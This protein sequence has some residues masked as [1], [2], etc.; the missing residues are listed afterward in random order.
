[1]PS[2]NNRPA[3]YK[4]EAKLRARRGRLGC[5]QATEVGSLRLGRYPFAAAIKHYEERRLGLVG[6]ST[7]REE[8]KTLRHLNEVFEQLKAEEEAK[9]TED[10]NRSG[11]EM[12]KP[13]TTDPRRMG[14][15][16]IQTFMAWMRR[17]GLDPATQVTYMKRLKNFLKVFRN[18]VIDDMVAD[19]VRFPK[20]P[21]KPIRTLDMDDLQ[22]IFQAAERLQGWHGAM[23][24]GMF[25]LYF[26]TGVR[27]SELRLAHFKDL[28]MKKQTLVI[29]HPKGEGSWASQAP[30][31]LIRP[32][33]VPIIERYLKERQQHVQKA[34]YEG[35]LALFPNLY[36]GQDG[37]YSANHFKQIKKKV[38]EI[39]GVEFKLKDFRPTLTSI[40]VNGDM[41][42]L[43]AM[44]AQLRHATIATT[45]R[46]YYSMQQGVAG[47][48][49]KKSY[50][51]P[52]SITAQD[53]V[54]DKKWD[55]SGY[56]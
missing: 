6:D 48:Q 15:R 38:E 41:S 3:I 30:V 32:D 7:M 4:S 5:K 44:S 26:A 39:S 56:R 10:T 47:R 46:S 20:N 19:G 52:G 22:V 14:R 11:G 1:M 55:I 28:D 23:A 51:G 8:L 40:T 9:D 45:Q 12:S 21:T 54:I 33:M 50:K 2:L 31:D 43:P 17:R 16:E 25:A 37:F 35:A 27:P 49:L 18:H 53:P 24:R 29:Q 36:G 13:F 42:L 34:G